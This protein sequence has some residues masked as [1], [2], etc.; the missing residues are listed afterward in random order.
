MRQGVVT[1][2]LLGMVV[3]AVSGC[4]SESEPEHARMTRLVKETLKEEGIQAGVEPV[5]E[6][7]RKGDADWVG[8]ATYGQIIYDLRVY[9]D[10]SGR[11]ML[12]RRMRAPLK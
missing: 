6:L 3:L 8:T 5:V 10:A 1:A 9:R 12:E 4:K 2:V 11:L 7:T